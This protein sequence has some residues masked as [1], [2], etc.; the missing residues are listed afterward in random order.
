MA[1]LARA[2]SGEQ[3]NS[4]FFRPIAWWSRNL[5]LRLLLLDD[6]LLLDPSSSDEELLLLL[7]LVLLPQ[8]RLPPFPLFPP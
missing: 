4:Q 5:L 7:L 1:A 3:E 2:P 6:L 8:L